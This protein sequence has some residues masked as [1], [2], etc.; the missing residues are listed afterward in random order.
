MK[1]TLKSISA[2]VR[3]HPSAYTDARKKEM[4]KLR[5][6]KAQRSSI[7]KDYNKLVETEAAAVLKRDKE[8]AKVAGK[9]RQDFIAKLKEDGTALPRNEGHIRRLSVYEIM[10]KASTKAEYQ[11]P[12]DLKNK[13][14]GN[15]L[16]ENKFAQKVIPVLN[17][18]VAKKLSSLKKEEQIEVMNS[19]KS[20]LSEIGGK[21]RTSMDFITKRSETA[22][23]EYEYARDSLKKAKDSGNSIR[24]KRATE[25]VAEARRNSARLTSL[26]ASMQKRKDTAKSVVEKSK[27]P[28][29]MKEIVN[30]LTD[31]HIGKVLDFKNYV[32]KSVRVRLLNPDSSSKP[33]LK[34]KKMATESLV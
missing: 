16:V 7:L 15:I 3:R 21:A 8:A 11:K 25:K 10:K 31:H 4:M 22:E 14:A 24:I 2:G 34:H 30:K 13:E 5:E 19:V 29:G 26:V 33:K 12:S 18:D 32:R 17:P 23:K 20:S 28:E 27:N 6:Q 9:A 1:L